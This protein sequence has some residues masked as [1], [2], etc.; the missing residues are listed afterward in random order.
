[1]VVVVNPGVISGPVLSQ[2]YELIFMQVQAIINTCRKG[3][4][5]VTEEM[6]QCVRERCLDKKV[7]K[8]SPTPLVVI[9][10]IH[11]YL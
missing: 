8:F 3:L 1:M 6:L 10:K 9:V 4:H 2:F 7:R 11:N 5:L